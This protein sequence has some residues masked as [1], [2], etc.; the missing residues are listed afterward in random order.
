MSAGGVV[1]VIP[2]F[3]VSWSIEGGVAGTKC[4][5]VSNGNSLTFDGNGK[6]QVC[7]QYLDADSVGA[8]R[9]TFGMGGYQTSI[10]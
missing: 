10:Q 8:V 3:H 1:I 7:T 6:R 5:P 9:F 2:V 4:G